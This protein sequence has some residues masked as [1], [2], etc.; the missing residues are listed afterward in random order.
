M[1]VGITA[2]L[3]IELLLVVGGPVFRY[4]RGLCTCMHLSSLYPPHPPPTHTYIHIHTH[5]HPSILPPL[6]HTPSF[7]H[8]SFL[9]PSLSLHSPQPLPEPTPVSSVIPHE[10]FGN[11]V[12]VLEFLNTFGPL[13]D[14]K[15]VIRGG[16]TIGKPFTQLS[17][18]YCKSLAQK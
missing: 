9:P 5:P 10:Q 18:L 3:C 16:I 14:I 8:C 12:M 1:Y 13:F 6:T 17:L 7:V 4:P 15:E 2:T 11:A